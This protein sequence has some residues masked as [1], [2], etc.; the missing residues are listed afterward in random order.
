MHG[1]V[2]LDR[3]GNPVRPVSM[4][5]CH[6]QHFPHSEHRKAL[7]RA[8]TSAQQNGIGMFRN[9]TP[10]VP[11]EAMLCRFR[12]REVESSDHVWFECEGNANLPMLM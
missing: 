12:V 6:Y 7:T 9:A 2:E 5:L 4:L 1:R 8:V 3:E 10:R 11:R